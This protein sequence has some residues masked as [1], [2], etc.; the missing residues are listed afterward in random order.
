MIKSKLI[1]ST[2]L[3]LFY[4]H[5]ALAETVVIVN[6]ANN[7]SS[8]KN[9]ELKKIFKGKTKA[10]ANG[11]PA[12]PI[13]LSEGSATRNVFYQKT[14]KKSPEKMKAYWAK[15]VFSGAAMPPHDG[16][17]A[18]GVKTWVSK[19]AAAIGYIDSADVD[20]TIKVISNN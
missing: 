2:L 1:A 16:G 6:P 9:S 3:M 5:M 20:G 15:S 18:E 14:M 17:D 13:D 11:S 10:F 4:T 7:I 8:I 12:D 19:N